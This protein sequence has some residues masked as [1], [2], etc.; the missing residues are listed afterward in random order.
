MDRVDE[1]SIP[2]A[3]QL[4]IKRRSGSLIIRKVIKDHTVDLI[5]IN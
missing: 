5:G 2:N 4:V 1:V 3:S